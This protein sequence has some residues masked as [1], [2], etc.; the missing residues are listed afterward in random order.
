MTFLARDCCMQERPAAVVGCPPK[1][2]V[3]VGE[4]L[5]ELGLPIAHEVG[6][7]E[8]WTSEVHDNSCSRYRD[9]SCEITYRHDL[10]ELG[11]CVSRTL[12]SA[13]TKVVGLAIFQLH[14]YLRFHHRH[15]LIIH[16]HQRTILDLIPLCLGL[17]TELARN[18][19]NVGQD[20]EPLRVLAHL[21]QQ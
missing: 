6:L 15:I 18:D 16:F 19:D 14:C 17:E 5:A 9:Q 8:A 13:Q 10:Q 3:Q 11:Q 4:V 12:M 21:G 1:L 20:A 7:A 2:L